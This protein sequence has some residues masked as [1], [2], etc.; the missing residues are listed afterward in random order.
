MKL[1]T[2]SGIVIASV[3]LLRCQVQSIRKTHACEMLIAIDGS[4]YEKFDKNMHVVSEYVQ[5][6]V[7]ELNRFFD[8]NVFT[9]DCDGIYFQVKEIRIMFGFCQN[10]THGKV[11][12][13]KCTNI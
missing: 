12:P 6:L 1:L 7:K 13:E 2:F 3:I 5:G 4:L 11:K 9:E 10:C 8:I